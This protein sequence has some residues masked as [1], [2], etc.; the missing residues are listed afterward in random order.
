MLMMVVNQSDSTV[1]DAKARQ[2]A[3]ILFKNTLYLN[4]FK[5]GHLTSMNNSVWF[6][7]SQ[8]TQT[9]IKSA[10]LNNL[11]SNN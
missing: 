7:I 8:E 2:L 5:D 3:S 6:Q 9:N 11:G 4:V 10:L 1:D